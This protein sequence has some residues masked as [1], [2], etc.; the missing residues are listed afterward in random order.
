VTTDPWIDRTR[1]VIARVV[2]TSRVAADSG[3]ETRLTDGY[4]LDSVELLEVLIA[5][6]Q[7]FGIVF[8]ETRDFAEGSLVTLGS[9][10]TLIRTRHAAAGVPE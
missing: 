1:A 8:E 10:A 7:E 9:L 6:E 3:A 2:G 4:W 5:C